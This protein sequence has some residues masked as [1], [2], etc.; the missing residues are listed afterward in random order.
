MNIGQQAF[1]RYFKDGIGQSPVIIH[2]DNDNKLTAK[3]KNQESY[4]SK[5]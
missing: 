3:Q 5:K 4:L 1:G 2:F